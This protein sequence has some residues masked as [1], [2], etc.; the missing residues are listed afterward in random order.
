M[1]KQTS[2]NVTT[3]RLDPTDPRD[4]DWA[5]RQRRAVVRFDV[6]DTPEGP[7]PLNPIT[8][9]AE[10]P[11]GR[12]DLW[13]WGE[14]V[15]SDAAVFGV[16][17]D[18]ARR[19]L[20]VERNDGHGWALPG[21]GLDD[22]ETPRAAAV[23]E[24][25]EETGLKLDGSGFV[26]LPARGVPDPR[27]GRHAWMV[28]VPGFVWLSGELPAVQGHDDARQAAW[29]PA[30]SYSELAALVDVFPAHV[31]LLREIVEAI[32]GGLWTAQIEW[33]RQTI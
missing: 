14:A 3:N 23:R 30:D 33:L 15:N 24:L 22:G 18:G 17:A 2:Y 1:T 12:G 4:I 28:T 6:I 7:R 13:H 19:V 29:I 20:M 31:E 26:M 21:G 11:E 27:S 25:R 10:L 5:E 16:D 32:D 8:D 9:P